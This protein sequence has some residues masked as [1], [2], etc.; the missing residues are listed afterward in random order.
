[1]DF[2]KYRNGLGFQKAELKEEIKERL[3]KDDRSDET[4]QM[5]QMLGMVEMQLGFTKRIILT[6]NKADFN[7]DQ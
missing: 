4:M 1:M 5:L 7:V 6:Q 2:K 3:L